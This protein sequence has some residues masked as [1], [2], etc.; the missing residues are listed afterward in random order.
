[1]PFYDEYPSLNILPLASE[2][3][4]LHWSLEIAVFTI[5]T[6]I[7][8]LPLVSLLPPSSLNSSWSGKRIVLDWDTSGGVP[9]SIGIG[10]SSRV[11]L[12]S[13]PATRP[14]EETWPGV[15]C[16]SGLFFFR[17]SR[18]TPVLVLKLSW[19]K[20][21]VLWG[22]S[23]FCVKTRERVRGRKNPS[24]PSGILRPCTT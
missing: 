1:M 16:L 18:S 11:S 9:G 10:S 23:E 17:R 21:N 22:S 6:K 4:S 14:W 5:F 19:P 8:H 2:S 3:L 24:F 20:E 12:P 13:T 7:T 15:D